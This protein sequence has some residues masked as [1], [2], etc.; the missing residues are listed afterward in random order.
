MIRNIYHRGGP[1]ISL[2]GSQIVSDC[3]AFLIAGSAVIAIIGNQPGLAIIVL[4]RQAQCHA[5]G[6]S[7]IGAV[8]H[9]VV[10]LVG[11]QIT[12][13]LNGSAAV[14]GVSEVIAAIKLRAVRIDNPGPGGHNVLHGL[15]TP[16]VVTGEFTIHIITNTVA[17]IKTGYER[18]AEDRRLVGEESG[19]TQ[20]SG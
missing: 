12:I 10:C 4:G 1:G 17:G 16:L 15:V 14:I 13:E 2:T 7:D 8:Q 9:D 6:H 5:I 3:F 20:P 11:I 19:H 18:C